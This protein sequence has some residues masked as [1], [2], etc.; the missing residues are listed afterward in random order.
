MNSCLADE[1]TAF[2]TLPVRVVAVYNL[3]LTEHSILE[4]VG[5]TNVFLNSKV[6]SRRSAQERC[7]FNC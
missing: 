1:W 5:K 6:T 7:A 2:L 4:I 3:L